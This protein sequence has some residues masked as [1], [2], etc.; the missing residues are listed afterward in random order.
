MIEH[1]LHV[2]VATGPHEHR[3]LLGHDDDELA[4]RAIAA[5]GA[6]AAAPELVAVAL[7]GVDRGSLAGCRCRRARPWRRRS[8]RPDTTCLPFHCPRCSR[9][10]PNTARSSIVIERPQP[11]VSTPCGR[12]LPGRVL[13]A[14]WLEQS[15]GEVVE[16]PAAG[17]ALHD[18]REQ[19]RRRR[20]VDPV[21]AGLVRDGRCEHVPRPRDV[22]TDLILRERLDVVADR[23]L[24]HV[25]QS[26]RGEVR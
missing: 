11:P 20:V 18:A 25:A 4:E 26:Q 22:G 2:G 17:D 15:R 3:I 16:H 21:G 6:V 13:D 24:E 8:T 7:L 23:H 9:N 12:L 5:V 1:R 14:E 19:I 10:C